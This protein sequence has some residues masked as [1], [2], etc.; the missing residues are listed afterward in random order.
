MTASIFTDQKF[1]DSTRD[2]VAK[3]Q[4]NAKCLEETLGA[5][6]MQEKV[7][8]ACCRCGICCLSGPC[9]MA[10]GAWNA[11]DNKPCPALK[12]EDDMATCGAL[13]MLTEEQ[14]QFAAFQLGIGYGCT[15]E[16]CYE[17]DMPICELSA[18]EKV[19]WARKLRE[20]IL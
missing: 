14:R 3:C 16:A 15:N 2:F 8:P 18:K 1:R 9:N 17:N 13:A 12:F 7:D 10:N 20:S 5:K 11:E 6:M 4:A 19:A